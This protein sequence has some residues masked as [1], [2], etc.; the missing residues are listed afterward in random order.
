MYCDIA[1][2]IVVFGKRFIRCFEISE[3]RKFKLSFLTLFYY[4]CFNQKLSSTKHFYLAILEE[5]ISWNILENLLLW[6][7]PTIFSNLIF[8]CNAEKGFLENKYWRFTSFWLGNIFDCSQ[9]SINQCLKLGI[10]I[11]T[12]RDV[13]GFSHIFALKN[14]HI[15]ILSIDLCDTVTLIDTYFRNLHSHFYQ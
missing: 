12:N 14:Q 1:E 5:V 13:I 7:L 11:L 3:Q 15:G 6:L 10:R 8:L 2:I 9:N 4:S